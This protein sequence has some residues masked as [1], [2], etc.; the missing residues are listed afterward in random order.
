MKYLKAYESFDTKETL[1]IYVDGSFYSEA[2]DKF[3]TSA[4]MITDNEDEYYLS[5]NYNADEAS[6]LIGMKMKITSYNAETVAVYEMLKI[7]TNVKNKVINIYTDCSSLYGMLNDKLKKT[8]Q[9]YIEREKMMSR[10]T[11]L[12]EKIRENNILDIRWIKGHARVY[13]NVIS[14]YLARKKNKFDTITSYLL[15]TKE[16][17]RKKTYLKI[18]EYGLDKRI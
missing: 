2:P 8:G 1:D 9:R 4:F 13:G 5:N 16:K 14:N 7:L 15:N 3:Y 12:M 18:P 6:N 10:F 17:H 11:E